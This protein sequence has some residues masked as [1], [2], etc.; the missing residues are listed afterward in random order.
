MALLHDQTW[1]VQAPG[2]SVDFID[3]YPKL[4][5]VCAK[6]GALPAVKVSC[7]RG[8]LL[9]RLIEK[10]KMIVKRCETSVFNHPF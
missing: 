7:Y 9:E 5:N 2:F 4:K 10:L 1:D 8:V 3:A 6:F